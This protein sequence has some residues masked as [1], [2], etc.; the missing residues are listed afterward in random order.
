MHTTPISLLDRLRSHPDN[1]EAWRQIDAIYRPWLQRWLRGRVA[2]ASDVDDLVQTVL[3]VLVQE[4]PRF[5]HNGNTGAFRTWLRGI[6]VNRLREF[7]R[8][9]A[10]LAAGDCD[11]IIEQLADAGS[12]LSRQWDREHDQ[13]VVNQLL[14]MI[15][16]DFEPRTW[17]A[18][19]AFVMDGER[20]AAIASRLGMSEGAVWT[21]K[22]HVL[23]R[24]RQVAKDWI[25]S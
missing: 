23:K 21:A 11:P 13:H 18:F 12:E 3:T 10:T 20:A 7:R 16:P 5:E 19:R 2:Q 8:G 25:D 15:E 17:A 22:S 9:L 6:V 14:R 1:A 24:L 4:L